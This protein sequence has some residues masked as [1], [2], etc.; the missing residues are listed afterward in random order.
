MLAKLET[1]Y[2]IY[3]TVISQHPL[4]GMYTYIHSKHNMIS[5]VDSTDAFG[6]FSV[7]GVVKGISRGMR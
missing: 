4:D 1:E 3:K 6:V 2:S 5:V 7:L